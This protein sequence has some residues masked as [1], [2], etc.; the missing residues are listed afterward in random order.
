MISRAR[1]EASRSNGRKSR[2]PR[3][4]AGR[5]CASHNALRHGLAALTYK[6]AAFAEVER[7]AK[8]ICNGDTNPLLFDQALVIAENEMVRRCVRGEAIAMIERL[9]DITVNPLSRDN[10][11]TR[12]KV[13]FRRGKLRYKQLVQAK[14]KTIA[15]TTGGE[16]NSLQ[17]Q[18]SDAAQSL[19]TRMQKSF[20][21]SNL[22]RTFSSFLAS[23]AHSA[24]R[25]HDLEHE[26]V[27]GKP[28][29]R[30][31]HV[32]SKL[33]NYGQNGLYKLEEKALISAFWRLCLSRRPMRHMP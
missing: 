29:P 12:A 13:R 31:R 9:R 24:E 18:E 32:R 10:S 20:V 19:P 33:A 4:A 16:K 23:P 11:L 5:S 28:R 15:T 6:P 2:G 1:A 25:G 26:D 3:T 30:A 7:I 17:E 8:A 21:P 14:A 22:T 27:F